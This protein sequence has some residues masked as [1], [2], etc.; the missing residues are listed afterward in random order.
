MAAAL[1]PSA[2]SQVVVRGGI[3]SMGELLDKPVE[4]LDAPDLFCLDLY[5]EFD[6]PQ[7][8]ALGPSSSSR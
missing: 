2:F 6:V 5:R 8:A 3:R 7:L 4:Y 1:E